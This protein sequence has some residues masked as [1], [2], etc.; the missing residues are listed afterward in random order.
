VYYGLK[1]AS[2]SEPPQ[3]RGPKTA[4][5]DEELLVLIQQVISER[6]QVGFHGEGYRKI[7]FSLRKGGKDRKPVRVA[8]GRLLRIMR[9]NELQSPY[10]WAHRPAK[11]HDGKITTDAPDEMWGTD[12]TS[13]PLSTGGKGYVYALVDHCTQE[14]LGFHVAD[15]ADRYS[16][17]EAVK[18]AVE[19]VHGKVKEDIA[20]GTVLRHDCGSSYLSEYF[21]D[22]VE[23][24]GLVSS[25]AFVREPQ[26]NGVVERFFKTLK[27]QL[28][29]LQTY[30]TIEE[31]Y[32]AVAE[33][34]KNYN[35][36]WMVAK[37]GY[38]SPADFRAGFIW[39]EAA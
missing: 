6:S 36:N 27:E 38:M 23:Y 4:V 1:S 16:T 8:Q 13:I 12:M 11:V 26:G 14:C 33:W 10:R 20:I 18:M 39:K 19:N 15:N 37:N 25:P 22:E 5:S 35:S 34:I 21:Q 29:W 28:L 30:S 7:L 9:E 32:K 3:K 31:L 24:L 17:F 2:V